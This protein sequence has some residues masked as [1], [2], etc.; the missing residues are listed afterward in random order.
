MTIFQTN[1]INPGAPA[2]V[3]IAL[4]IEDTTVATRMECAAINIPAGKSFRA[5]VYNGST[6]VADF[7]G[8]SENTTFYFDWVAA[9][10]TVY[11]FSIFIND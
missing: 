3:P 6:A 8:D 11:S 5:N 9:V 10:G 7:Y 2:I 4:L 1:I